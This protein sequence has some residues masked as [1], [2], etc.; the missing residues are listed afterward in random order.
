[1]STAPTSA[2]AA[3]SSLQ[4]LRTF[5]RGGHPAPGDVVYDPVPDE[6]GT[7]ALTAFGVDEMGVGEK[8]GHAS[9]RCTSRS[10]R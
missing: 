7:G 2:A 10:S 8:E 3:T 1:M 6:H 4:N 9:P 5:R